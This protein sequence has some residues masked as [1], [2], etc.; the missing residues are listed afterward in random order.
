MGGAKACGGPQSVY[1][2]EYLLS[3]IY[4]LQQSGLVALHNYAGQSFQCRCCF[5]AVLVLRQAWLPTKNHE[6]AQ[7]L[8]QFHLYK[9]L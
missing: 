5:I 6:K 7:E 3:L 4:S 2:I 1:D 8:L 9:L